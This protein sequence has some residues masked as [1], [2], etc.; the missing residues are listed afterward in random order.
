MQA[1][2]EPEKKS[3]PS[4]Q[5]LIDQMYEGNDNA[6]QYDA[7]SAKKK[8]VVHRPLKKRKAAYFFAGLSYIF[9]GL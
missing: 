9:T 7:S 2:P 3:E 5:E 1:S 4:M 8:T 6:E